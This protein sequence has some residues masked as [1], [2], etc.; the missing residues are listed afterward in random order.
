MCRNLAGPGHRFDHS[1]LVQG[2][3][4]R[5]SWADVAIFRT[6]ALQSSYDFAADGRRYD[7]LF[8]NVGN[9]SFSDCRR[10]LT[11]KGTYV[12]VGGPKTGK[13]LGPVKRLVAAKVRFAFASQ[14]SVSAIANITNK[15]L[16]ALVG[17]IESGEV[18]SVIDR[19]Y[20]LS[21]TADAVRYLAEGHA[22]GKVIIT[23]IDEPGAA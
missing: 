6:A 12:V 4:S 20:P 2:W 11:P 23:V 10:V 16:L 17:L 19:R 5:A 7:V 15:E 9:R 13:W 18:R 1:A 22:S 8:D 14:R 3:R 21:S